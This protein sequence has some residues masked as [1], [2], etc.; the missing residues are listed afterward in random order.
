MD[1]LRDDYT[2]I[3][4]ELLTKDKIKIIDN[5]YAIAHYNEIVD[6]FDGIDEDSGLW[7]E[8]LFNAILNTKGNVILKVWNGWL[9]YNHPEYYNFF[10]Y[11]DLIDIIND[12][13]KHS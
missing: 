1:K 8:E 7:D 2:E 3:V 13:I 5:A 4:K 10:N 12:T 11:E 6:M 9:N